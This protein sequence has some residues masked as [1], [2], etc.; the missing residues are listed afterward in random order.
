[1]HAKSPLKDLPLH[2]S[3][4][5]I[6]VVYMLCVGYYAPTTAPVFD[7]GRSYGILGGGSGYWG[8]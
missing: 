3:T 5:R 4:T 6:Y 8:D 2:G 7:R 1:M